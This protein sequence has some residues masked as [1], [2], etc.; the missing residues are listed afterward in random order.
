METYPCPKC[1]NDVHMLSAEAQD[2]EGRRSLVTA[3]CG[4]CGAKLRPK[5]TPPPDQESGWEIVPES[6]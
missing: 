6:D 5:P 2:E 3:K 4:N 1:G